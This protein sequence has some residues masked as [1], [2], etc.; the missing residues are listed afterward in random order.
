[1]SDSYP[2]P[3]S[4]CPPGQT[5]DSTVFVTDYYFTAL[6]A[7][8]SETAQ[9]TGA[10]GKQ[11]YRG[12]QIQEHSFSLGSTPNNFL[13][14]SPSYFANQFGNSTKSVIFDIQFCQVYVFDKLDLTI[15][16]IA[17]DFSKTLP[18]YI[19][20]DMISNDTFPAPV[21]GVGTAASFAFVKDYA[22]I[23]LACAV[24]QDV[25]T[26]LVYDTGL[27]RSVNLNTGQVRTLAGRFN[28]E[29]Y[30]EDFSVQKPSYGAGTDAMFGLISSISLSKDGSFAL[31]TDI[32][33][34][35]IHYINTI[36]GDLS[37]VVGHPLGCWSSVD[38]QGENAWLFYPISIAIFN[39]DKT[40]IFG[41]CGNYDRT[42]GS[43]YAGIRLLDIA[44]ST[45]TVIGGHWKRFGFEDN[46]NGRY[47]NLTCPTHLTVSSDESYALFIDNAPTF[48]IR[49][50]DLK[51]SYHSITTI[52][53][54]NLDTI[55]SS[56]SNII[57]PVCI[58]CPPGKYSVS[59]SDSSFQCAKCAVGTYTSQA[60]NTVCNL[61][62]AGF[63]TNSLGST[64]C[65]QCRV[66]T[67]MPTTGATACLSCLSASLC[68]NGQFR[69]GCSGNSLGHCASCYNT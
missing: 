63:Y 62:S 44:T 65:K 20:Y 18:R 33:N 8:N 64:A 39:N 66:D 46:D 30:F 34:S 35:R 29:A 38:G 6:K 13:L 45:T 27:I 23:G 3:A 4:L 21:D 54:M 5:L 36:T 19:R 26:A 51:S 28:V 55:P 69:V 57:Y 61:C 31:L 49:K 7:F 50:I 24:S 68:S 12:I 10:F 15:Q 59:L 17:G 60:S 52:R 32:L 40:A 14:G 47:A 67:Y 48:A 42:I 37:F 56:F 22:T 1:M 58:G 2:L 43:H 25:S 9:Y 11:L 16:V 41:E 53:A